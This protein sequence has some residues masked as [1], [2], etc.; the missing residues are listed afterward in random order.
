MLREYN[1][2]NLEIDLSMSVKFKSDG[3]AFLPMYVFSL[4]FNN[5]Y[6]IDILWTPYMNYYL[7][8]ITTYPITLFLFEIRR[9]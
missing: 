9:V 1:I 2:G 7:C 8:S 4:V 6:V 5:V 3:K